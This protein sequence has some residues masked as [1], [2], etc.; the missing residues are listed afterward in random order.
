MA[1]A[2]QTIGILFNA[3]GIAAGSTPFRT[4]LQAKNSQL[5]VYDLLS[6]DATMQETHSASAEVTEHPVEV[7]ADITDHIRPKPVELHIDGVITNSPLGSDLLRSAVSASPLGPGLA[8]GE[9]VAS[10]IIGKAEFI[11]DAFNTLRRIRDTGQLVVLATP[12]LQYE[13]MAMT[14]LQIVR[15]RD[16]GDALRFQ[17]TFR[18]IVTVEGAKTVTFAPIAQDLVSLGTQSTST[19]SGALAKSNSTVL[20]QMF[21]KQATAAGFV[22]PPRN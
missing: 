4:K 16:T 14:D 10:A 19:A 20:N 21:G 9:A 7:G 11:K 3:A 6:I 13:S 22:L 17:A 12:Y 18:Q 2:L 8:V 1:V 15:A 5:V